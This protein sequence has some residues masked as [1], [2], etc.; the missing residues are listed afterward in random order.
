MRFWVIKKVMVIGCCGSGKSTFS[1][2]MH[3]KTGITVY[4]LK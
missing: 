2:K 3:E 4:H 1:K